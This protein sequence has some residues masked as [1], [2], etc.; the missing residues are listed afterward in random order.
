EIFLMSTNLVGCGLLL[1]NLFVG[2]HVRGFLPR[3]LSTK[4]PLSVLRCRHAALN[5][6]SRRENCGTARL[7][8]MRHRFS[9]F[10]SDLSVFLQQQFLWSNRKISYPPPS[11]MVDCISDGRGNSGYAY[12]SQSPCSKCTDV[13][14][15]SSD[16]LHIDFWNICVNG[17]HIVRQ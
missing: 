8:V 3:R 10:V 9:S 14:I 17:D 5:V 16:K 7:K 13:G 11:C 12:L 6:A 4:S 1:G 15:G 2:G